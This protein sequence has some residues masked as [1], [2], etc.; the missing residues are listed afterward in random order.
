MTDTELYMTIGKNIKFY[1]KQNGLT[2]REF[3]ESTGISLSYL[4]KLEATNCVQSISLSL[5]NKISNSL[6]VDI[7]KFF[8]E[9]Y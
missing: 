7:I 1:R 6:N 8:E 3:C 5:L 9:R 2:Q 4:T